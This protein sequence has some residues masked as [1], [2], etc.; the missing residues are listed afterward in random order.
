MRGV[1]GFRG[2]GVPVSVLVLAPRITN[3]N[4]GTWELR[5]LGT[6]ELRN[7]GT[8]ELRNLGTPELRNLGTPELRNSGTPEPE[9]PPFSARGGILALCGR[10]LG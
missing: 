8:P 1:P 9:V 3:R 7:P 10:K 4:S 6:P 2:S 5:N